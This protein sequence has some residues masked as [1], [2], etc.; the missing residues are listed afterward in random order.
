MIQ[1]NY[2]DEIFQ[3]INQFKKKLEHLSI[4]NIKN[5][6]NFPEYIKTLGDASQSI[7]FINE[8]NGN[9]YTEDIE[10]VVYYFSD[11]LSESL[12]DSTHKC[13][14][15]I[16]Q[17]VY[18]LKQLRS[19]YNILENK[20]TI[21]FIKN[22]S[23]KNKNLHDQLLS[24][25]AKGFAYKSESTSEKNKPSLPL[26]KSGLSVS[27]YNAL[28]DANGLL[29]DDVFTLIGKLIKKEYQVEILPPGIIK[30]ISTDKC[31]DDFTNYIN[32]S[33]DNK[34]DRMFL[35]INLG[36]IHWGL[37][38]FDIVEKLVYWYDPV[39]QR[40]PPQIVRDTIKCLLTNEKDE[41]ETKS[42]IIN[43]SG[44]QDGHNCGVYVL[45]RIF[46]ILTTGDFDKEEI[47]KSTIKEVRKLFQTAVD[48]KDIEP[49]IE[50]ARKNWGYVE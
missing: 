17:N 8:I 28:V 13:I 19:I 37:L 44:Q 32:Q 45:A 18:A 6:G 14:E 31:F 21:T 40:E 26:H 47:D 20:S 48:T 15:T 16:Q 29:E 11:K 33:K 35:P 30:I 2:D 3:N 23:K 50:S 39:R 38:S 36:N 22:K 49:I 10:R 4:L 24:T 41:W 34:I 25:L 27:S 12:E 43:K 42:Q 46:E 7:N 9:Y 5:S 1:D